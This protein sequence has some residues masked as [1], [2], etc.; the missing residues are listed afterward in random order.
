MVHGSYQPIIGT[1]V[2]RVLRNILV[3]L[4]SSKCGLRFVCLLLKVNTFCIIGKQ[5]Q[6]IISVIGST[7]HSCGDRLFTIRQFVAEPSSLITDG[8]AVFVH[9]QLPIG[10][11]FGKFKLISSERADPYSYSSGMI[12]LRLTLMKYAHGTVFQTEG[13]R[14]FFKNEKNIYINR[15]LV[16]YHSYTDFYNNRCITYPVHKDI[17]K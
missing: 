4:W 14:D 3:L 6:Q 13:A 17:Y 15:V 8:N 10:K 12:K 2:F 16:S 5:G 11:K 1:V 7:K 9:E